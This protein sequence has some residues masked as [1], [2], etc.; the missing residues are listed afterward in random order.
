MN[1][2][3]DNISKL[4]R[5]EKLKGDLEKSNYIISNRSQFT[6]REYEYAS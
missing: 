5:K 2:L 1:D 4:K 3:A 6:Q